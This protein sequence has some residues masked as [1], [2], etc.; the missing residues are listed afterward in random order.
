MEA[1]VSAD[2]PPYV[3]FITQPM[4]NR[5]ASI[6]A[7]HYV[8]EDVDYVV[9][10][11]QGGK[12]KIEQETAAWFD[13]LKGYFDVETNKIVEEESESIIIFDSLSIL[14]PD[15]I[16][17]I[18]LDGEVTRNL[19]TL[20]IVDLRC[21]TEDS[22]FLINGTIVNLLGGNHD[23]WWRADLRSILAQGRAPVCHS[24]AH[25]D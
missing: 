21:I 14:I 10:I 22:D 11:P 4:E 12:D 1:N 25:R 5:N 15:L 9:I 17:V 20:E 8:A 3:E 18:C 19:D 13:K 2:R 24:S 23:Y 16:S 6:K 7:G